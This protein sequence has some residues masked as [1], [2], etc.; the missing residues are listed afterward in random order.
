M[1]G[2]MNKWEKV[3]NFVDRPVIWFLFI[4]GLGSIVIE[5]SYGGEE[6]TSIILLIFAFIVWEYE[7]SKRGK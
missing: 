4:F 2:I 7:R 5:E 3:K 1:V 6:L